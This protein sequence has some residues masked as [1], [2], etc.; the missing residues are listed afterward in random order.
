MSE[1][2]E[3]GLVPGQEVDFATL[4]RINKQR[5]TKLNKIEAVKNEST[6]KQPELRKSRKPSISNVE[7]AAKQKA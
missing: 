3:D 4:N 2:N 6:A 1:L 5:S 7:K